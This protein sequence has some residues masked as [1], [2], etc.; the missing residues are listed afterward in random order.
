MRKSVMVSLIFHVL[1]GI[2]A[3]LWLLW[4]F[5]PADTLF[6][7]GMTVCIAALAVWLVWRKS[8][9]GQMM[10]EGETSV[11]ELPLPDAGG[12]VVLVC[13]DELD[14]LFQGQ[15]LRKT[16]QGWWLRVNDVNRLSDIVRD[17]HEQ[18]PRQTGQLSVMYSCQPDRHLDE[19]VLRASLKALRQQMKQLSQIAGFSMPVILSGEF[20]GPATPWLVV[21]GDKPVVYPA[22]ET[23]QALDDWQ[24]ENHLALMPV[25]R[26][27]FAFMRTILM[28][29]LA[30]EDRLFPAVHPFAVAF[31]S[32]MA[33]VDTA[34]LWSHHLCRLTHLILPQA[35]GAAGVSGRFPDAVLPVLA[36]YCAPV[37]GGQRTRRLVLLVLV[38]VLTALGFSAANNAALIRHVGTD[39]QRWYAIPMNHYEPKAQSLAA[40]KQDALL[41]ERWQRQGEPLRYALGYYP[42]QRL[43]LALQKAIDTYVPPS[44]PAPKSQPKIIRLDSMSLFDTGKWALKPGST[45]LLVNSLVGIKAKPGWLIVVAGHTDSTGDDKSNQELSLKRAESVRDWMRD[46]GDVPESCFAVQGYGESRPVATNDTTEGRALNRRVEISLVPQANACQLPGNTLAPSQDDG[47]SK[48][49]M[50]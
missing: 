42:G 33:S 10:A 35:A 15:T 34:S 27:A 5:I 13:G 22:D 44:A 26:E 17:I 39:L 25:L 47:V 43:W 46:T 48:N 23:P 36:P 2:A 16:A 24:Q 19:A 40:L 12:P 49:E 30:K 50:E 8:R 45:K 18:Q 9:S 11:C 4:G 7:G 31:R 29:E 6:K 28:D 38:C 14:A 37:Q 20:S 3:L 1:A 32:G 41:L 21:R